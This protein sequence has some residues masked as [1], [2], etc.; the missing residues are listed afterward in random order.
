MRIE[1]RRKYFG[2]VGKAIVT[3][4]PC[5]DLKFQI[6]HQTSKTKQQASEQQQAT[7]NKQQTKTFTRNKNTRTLIQQLK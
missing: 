6:K 3:Y 2:V 1:P 5:H 4:R 7:S